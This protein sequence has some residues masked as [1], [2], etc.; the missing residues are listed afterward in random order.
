M[1]MVVRWLVCF[2][3][4]L[5]AVF[6]HAR[7]TVPSER[8]AAQADA[9]LSILERNGR[10]SGAVLVARDGEVIL[11]KGYGYADVER[12][13]PYT[14]A[15]QH[16]IAS[17]SKMFTAMAA[18]RLRDDG[19]LRLSDSVCDHVLPCPEAWQPV[20][21]QHL[22]HHT[23]GIPDYE[24][25]LGLGSEAYLAYM[26]EPNASRRIVDEARSLPLDFQPGK[27]FKY[28]NTGYILLAYIVQQAAGIPFHE[29]VIRQI[30]EPSGME[31]SGTLGLP[32]RP[33]SLAE[34]YAYGP[35]GWAPASNDC[36]CVQQLRRM[37]HLPYSPPQG[38]A[39]MYST[40][41]DL[42][43]WGRIMDGQG[44][45]DRD[46]I[47]EIETPGAT[48]EG[49]G[50]YGDG[51]FVG[52]KFDRTLVE[53]SGGLPGYV[54]NFQRYVDDKVTII[55][56]S[57]LFDAA[58]WSISRD[59]GAIVF[60]QPYDQPRRYLP[61]RPSRAQLARLKGHY[62][63]EDGVMRTVR[64]K[65]EH[66][67]M[68]RKG[69]LAILLYPVSPNRFYAPQI[70]GQVTF[71]LDTRGRVASLNLRYEATDHVAKRVR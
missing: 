68:A 13:I 59:L 19:K 33:R 51:W 40:V 1:T 31:E 23:S 6:A 5:A 30:L 54:S 36:L 49:I 29:Y 56:F 39:W 64:K 43:R 18:L 55:L 34:G 24:E 8:I 11:R 10:F 37:P 15:T 63:S 60:G 20:T 53:H 41:D 4:L 38:D 3:L 12:R 16:Q 71:A 17:I 32:T 48:I 57:N 35:L 7:E 46:R 14:P 69:G 62:R 61:Y 67:L 47:A 52:T 65:G 70:E 25:K 42:Y 58:V 22:M 27:S 44:W 21:V 45:L 66:L 50:G 28:S 2:S 26:A 9:Y